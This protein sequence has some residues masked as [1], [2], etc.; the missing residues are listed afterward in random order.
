M[1][2]FYNNFPSLNENSKENRRSRE[3]KSDYLNYMQ[4]YNI[5]KEKH[6]FSDPHFT[7]NPSELSSK[8]Q[9][10]LSEP[11]QE[12]SNSR[13]SQL[14][15]DLRRNPFEG[16]LHDRSQRENDERNRKKQLYQSELM[17][18]IDQKRKEHQSLKENERRAEEKLT[19]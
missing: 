7:I 14:V 12:R 11:T 6:L 1:D 4:K 17:L 16:Q 18:Q 2:S 15:D 10:Y 5:Q 19:R 13:H 3:G 8:Q 9:E